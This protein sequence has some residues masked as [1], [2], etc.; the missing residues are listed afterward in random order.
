MRVGQTTVPPSAIQ[1]VQMSVAGTFG[2]NSGPFGL[3]SGTVNYFYYHVNQAST[4][5][6]FHNA[7]TGRYIR[8]SGTYMIA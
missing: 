2:T 7:G 1:T 4:A 6:V 5:A 8:C 3:V